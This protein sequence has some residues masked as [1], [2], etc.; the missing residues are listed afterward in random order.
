MTSWI[1]PIFKIC[2]LF[3]ALPL[4]S[5]SGD[6]KIECVISGY[7]EENK[8]YLMT[9]F[10][11]FNPT[12]LS[13][14]S[15]PE[16]KKIC[17]FWWPNGFFFCSQID[18]GQMCDLIW[19]DHT[20]NEM[21]ILHSAS[22]KVLQASV[23]YS[24][25]HCADRK[26][27]ALKNFL[28]SFDFTLFGHWYRENE[29]GHAIFVKKDLFAAAMH[30]LNYSP[31]NF[32]VASTAL[33]N[34]LEKHFKQAD[35]KSS[36]HKINGIDFIYMINLDERPEKFARTSK[37][38]EKFGIVPYRFSAVNG[39]KLTTEAINQV[40]VKFS[41]DF[42]KEKFLGSI[43]REL[44]GKECLGNEILKSNGETFFSLGMSR[45]AIGIVLSHLSVLQ[46]AYNSGY[47]TIWV[48]EDDVEVLND[49]NT[50]S[51][52]IP[53]LDQCVQDWDILFTDTDTKDHNGNHV[54]CRAI[55][56]RPNVHIAPLAAFLKCFHPISADFSRIGMR[57][58]AYSMI[59]RR[60]GMEKILNYFKTY[61]IFLPYDMDIWLNPHLKMYSVNKDLISHKAGSPS[62]NSYPNYLKDLL[63]K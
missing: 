47:K 48:M 43:Y 50:I 18:A 39:W 27:H 61:G 62:D 59:I 1:H 36:S 60:S 56:A 41:S 5:A 38:L 3:F 17:E 29:E 53:K 30:T 15:N 49:P 21:D 25:T 19:I 57:Y 34:N 52:L 4:F 11:P 55:A 46:D 58:G 23:I 7:D 6:R 14:T 54:P 45:G 44:D 10:L 42:G 9:L 13:Y 16:V 33:Q 26:D 8:N 2:L 28:E 63:L 24:V 31:S 32:N 37:E 20:E 22:D 35:H 51:Q 40:G 12:I